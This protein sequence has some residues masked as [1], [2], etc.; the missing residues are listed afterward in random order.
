MDTVVGWE[1]LREAVLG[2]VCAWG[3]GPAESSDSLSKE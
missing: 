3:G 2:Q 1:G